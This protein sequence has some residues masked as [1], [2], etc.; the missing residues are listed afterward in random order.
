MKK[1]KKDFG[2]L[3]RDLELLLIGYYL[4]KKGEMDL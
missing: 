4:A 3:W 2:D 1:T